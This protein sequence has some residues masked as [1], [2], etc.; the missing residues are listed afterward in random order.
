MNP[1]HLLIAIIT[2]I[3]A[4]SAS[5]ASPQS[6]KVWFA[7]PTSST[8]GEAWRINDFSATSE[9][10]DPQWESRSLPIG[11]G[12]F[13]ATILGSIARERI[14]INEK[15][16]WMGGPATGP[17]K[18][19]DMNRRVS[20]DSLAKIRRLLDEGNIDAA[21]SLT[22]N[23]FRGTTPYDRSR[24]GTYTMMGEA[25][26]TTDID[27]AAVSHYR[28]E[29]DIDSA[30]VRVSFQAD[31][32]RYTR[33]YFASYPDSV[34]LWRFSSEG[35]NQNLTFR[36]SSPHH[37][38]DF[39][40]PQPGYLIYHGRLE[41]NQMQWALGVQ[42]R[43]PRGGRIE[44]DRSDQTIR[45]SDAPCIEFIVAGDTDYA[46]NF[47]PDPTDANA[48]VGIDPIA[49]VKRN[50]SQAGAQ[51]FASLY[52]RHLADY[53]ALYGRV[54]LDLG[55]ADRSHLDTPR[56][57]AMYRLGLPDPQ[58][59]QLYFQFGRYL[60][61]A[62]SRPGT[63]PANLQGLWHNN[64]DG[65]WRVDYHNNINLQMNYWPATSTNLTECFIPLT[66]YIR[67]IVEP[68]R[69]TASAYYGARGWTTEVSTNIFGFT[70]PLDSRDM[71]WN[72]NP[73]AGPWLASQLWEYYDFTRNRDWLARIA[74]PIIRESALFAS[75]LLVSHQGHLS[76]SPSYS[77]EHGP[78]DPGATYAN[79][80]TRQILSEAIRAAAELNADTLLRI[81]WQQQLDS[82]LPYRIGRY[83]QLQEWS[84]DIDTYCD[85]HR[86]TNH[87]FGLHPGN[88]IDALTDT[89][90]AD[91]CR[92][93][94][95]QRGD[96]AT[97]WSMGWKLNHWARLR[98]GNHA[99][100]LLSNLLKNGTA[101]NLWDQHPPF[102]I[103]GNFGG[104]AGIAEMLLQSHA[105]RIDLLPALPAAWPT[106]SVSGLRARGNFTVDIDF[107]DGR[108]TRA[109]IHSHS[110]LPATV[111]YGPHTFHLPPSPPGTTH[112]I[113]P[114]Q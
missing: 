57:L 54:T 93:T 51:S 85:P 45:I 31:G 101:D 1:H 71:S 62:S 27:E 89:T 28:R 17:E 30:I 55:G 80:V 92:E 103:D 68:G 36:F 40:A 53:S 9:N 10:P 94:L 11:N 86:H 83:G 66:D 108:L 34:M 38:G 87:L 23:E 19:W 109:Q 112:L 22:A 43:L 76:S 12:A 60:L 91:A 20:A 90:L 78:I 50:I 100:M 4:I 59:E 104:T 13:G 29:L 97:G 47:S 88:T 7:E 32:V 77:P 114:P 111:T 16:L 44:T 113:L 65:P 102:Q 84:R 33:E 107:A 95:R 46:M 96:A 70:A 98:D 56:R 35:G 8:G 110:G 72:Y 79:A 5:A 52:S 67:S 21:H 3:S 82:I 99:H 69:R 41:G 6:N 73:M 106:G 39:L 15:T 26:I 81:R 24:F 42:V 64:I 48:Y 2:F 49:A 75:D 63:M 105:G 14:V 58:L 18:Y 61:I 25:F 74:Y 37:K